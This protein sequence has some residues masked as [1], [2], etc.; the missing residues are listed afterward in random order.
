LTEAQEAV[1]KFAKFLARAWQTSLAL[2]DHAENGLC[3]ASNGRKETG[4]PARQSMR[5]QG[6]AYVNFQDRKKP[7]TMKQARTIQSHTRQRQDHLTIQMF[8]VSW[9]RGHGFS[10][11]FNRR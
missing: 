3:N 6:I 2:Q 4:S 11:N 8:T 5:L 1:E 7:I 9:Q 10:G